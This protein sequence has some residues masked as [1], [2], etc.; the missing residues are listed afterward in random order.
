MKNNLCITAPVFIKCSN[1]CLWHKLFLPWHLDLLE[2][3]DKNDR[4]LVLNL[5]WNTDIDFGKPISNLGNIIPRRAAQCIYDRICEMVIT[6]I[7]R[8][9]EVNA[10][11]HHGVTPLHMAVLSN[12]E[13]CTM[14]LKYEANVNSATNYGLRIGTSALCS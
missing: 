6:W 4:S 14:L 2:T 12:S 7:S 9:V 13:A 5:L 10:K 3:F 8:T 11:T 1:R